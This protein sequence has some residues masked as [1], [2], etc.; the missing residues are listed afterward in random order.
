MCK[1]SAG[2]AVAALVFGGWLGAGEPAKPADTQDWPGWLGA[3]RDGVW[4]ETGTLTKFPTGGPKVLW[5]TPIGG[6]NSGPAVAG[7]KVYVMDRHT[8]PKKEGEPAPPRGTLP[9]TERVVCLDA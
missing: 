1:R 8:P 5:R 6:G 2:L 7:G 9:G 4:R 3:Q